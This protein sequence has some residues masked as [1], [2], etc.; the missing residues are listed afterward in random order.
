MKRS[1]SRLL[2]TALA[3]AV[4]TL[5]GHVRAEQYALLVAI[6]DYSQVNGASN[7][8]GCA[9]DLAGI[10]KWLI[11]D[12]GFT[13]RHIEVLLDAEA[14]KAAF[15]K[16]LD[17]VVTKAKPGDSVLVYYSGH[18]AQLPDLN[19]D[20]ETADNLDETLITYDFDRFDPETWLLDDHLRSILSRL[21]TKRAIVLLDACHSGTATRAGFIN[22]KVEFGFENMLGRGRVDDA[23]LKEFAGGPDNHV[24]FAACSSN[25]VSAI[26]RYGGV[27]R[28]LFTTAF[29]DLVPR[30]M[31]TR[32]SDF[33]TTLHQDM[34]TLH[35]EA[36][37][38]QHPQVEA[39]EE[40]TLQALLGAEPARGP[41]DGA[42][43]EPPAP[44][45]GD[46]L[47]TAFK[48]SVVTDKRDYI[49]GE[50]LVATVT[51]EKAGFLRL[52]YVDQTGDATLVFPNHFQKNNAIQAN[53]RVEIGGAD[54]GFSF[55]LKE[56]GGSELLLAVVSP[57]PFSDAKDFQFT[58]AKPCAELGKVKSIPALAERG[59]K[60]IEVEARPAN[61]SGVPA[62]R[63][64][65]IGRAACLYQI[66]K[67]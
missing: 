26:G 2:P 24:L 51:S 11:Q 65:Q 17:Q 36:A 32:L 3:A 14:T 21:K 67:K 23:P 49:P 35:R 5:S 41:L 42:P 61:A 31:A 13:E 15:L 6:E 56:P 64:V 48:V 57:E 63:P 50:F 46:G 54:A 12:L 53:Q 16:K 25:E 47:P 28:S 19:D 33:C 29:L 34:V 22:K 1:L 43:V 7:L 62:L 10:K 30:N 60:R 55:M 59:T 38:A 27:H 8:P 39:G 40:F 18:G 37:Q 52:Y 58:E 66:L 9:L 44:A 20:D 45:V 4:L